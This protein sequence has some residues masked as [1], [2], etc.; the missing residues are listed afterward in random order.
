MAILLKS[1]DIF[2]H[3]PKTGGNWVT[4][5]LAEQNLILDVI[6]HKHSDV[7]HT[8]S[9]NSEINGKLLKYFIKKKIGLLKS[10]PF[11]FCMVRHPLSWFESWY[12][13]M[14]QDK[15][16][17]KC[18][19]R[20]GIVASWHPNAPLDRCCHTS[21]EDFLHW[22]VDNRP[23]YVSHL[24]NAYT[25][26]GVD[27]V[28]KQENLACDLVDALNQTSMSFDAER[29]M[30]H[31]PVGVSEFDDSKLNCSSE[32]KEEILKL[33]YSALVKYGYVD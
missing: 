20:K 9:L 28:G 2:L 16:R 19:G 5:V 33:E 14:S 31:G 6:G 3:I 22:I 8:F 26:E 4:R 25:Y 11:V 32:I 15:I 1:G 12:K 17:W 23:G 18:W 10:K 24:L 13:Y 29:I 7:A 21:F 30:N 27:F